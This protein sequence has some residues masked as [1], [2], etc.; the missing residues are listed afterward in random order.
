MS[1]IVNKVKEVLH[2]HH[3]HATTGTT[4]TTGATG[5]T[6]STNAGPHTVRLM[7]FLI[8]DFCLVL[9]FSI[10]PWAEDIC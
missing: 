9:C 2:P 4:H 8:D 5:T 7:C 1:N 10:S 6:G 3:D